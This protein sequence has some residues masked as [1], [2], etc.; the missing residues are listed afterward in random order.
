MLF[1]KLDVPLRLYILKNLGATGA[2]GDWGR[3]KRDLNYKVKESMP[4]QFK[5]LVTKVQIL[6]QNSNNLKE[7]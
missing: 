2:K 5:W 1:F 6:L 3:E 4:K 7:F